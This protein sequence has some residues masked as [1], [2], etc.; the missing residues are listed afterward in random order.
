LDNF[1]LREA[2][3]KNF[4]I[5][6]LHLMGGD[7]ADLRTQSIPSLVR[8]S[9]RKEVSKNLEIERTAERSFRLPQRQTHERHEAM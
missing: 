1:R 5:G 8:L 6:G 7:A 4:H 9:Q 2:P 3:E